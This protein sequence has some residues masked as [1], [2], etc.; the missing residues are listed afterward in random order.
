MT[1]R[2]YTDDDVNL[3][4]AAWDEHAVAFY[5]GLI[6]E[7]R[8]GS[9]EDNHDAKVALAA[10]AAAA[11]LAPADDDP[12]HIAEFR[13]EGWCIQHPLACR[14][15]GGL[16]GCPFNRA[17]LALDSPPAQLGRFVVDLSDEGQG[18]DLVIGDRVGPG[19]P[20]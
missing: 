18:G 7:C 17:A 1:G 19:V 13:D 8:C 9:R 3:I 2:P 12:R 6:A 16:F 11:R 5:D 15:N 4:E 20:L 14:Q 10:L